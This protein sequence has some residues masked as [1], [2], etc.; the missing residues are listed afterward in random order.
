MLIRLAVAKIGLAFLVHERSVSVRSWWAEPDSRTQQ[1]W[2]KHFLQCP[3]HH[4]ISNADQTHSTTSTRRP[5]WPSTP[6]VNHTI[7]KL[8]LHFFQQTGQMAE[9]LDSRHKAPNLCNLHVFFAR[10]IDQ[11]HTNLKNTNKRTEVYEC[12]FITQ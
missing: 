2:E 10:C 8:D 12:T 1:L 11:K 5:T 7:S 9:P 6:R 3:Y 4:Q